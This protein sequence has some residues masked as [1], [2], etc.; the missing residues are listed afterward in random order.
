MAASPATAASAATASSPAGVATTPAA[1]DGERADDY[2]DARCEQLFREIAL[3]QLRVSEL[4]G[5]LDRLPAADATA[6]VR[7]TLHRPAVPPPGAH[8]D[9][10]TEYERL[11]ASLEAVLRALQ[12]QA[13]ATATPEGGA[14]RP[15][16]PERASA[17]P[18]AGSAGS[19]GSA[20]TAGTAGGA[21]AEGLR[22]TGAPTD[23]ETAPS[24]VAALPVSPINVASMR[25]PGRLAEPAL[26]VG[27][28]TLRL[29][30][31]EWIVVTRR[32]VT[33]RYRLA[34]TLPAPSGTL[35]D[36]W[37]IVALRREGAAVTGA[38]SLTAPKARAG[39]L[40]SLWDVDAC[41]AGGLV[42]REDHSPDA[43]RPDCVTLRRV[44]S[45]D[46]ALER[47]AIGAGLR[48]ARQLGLEVDG[49]FWEARAARYAIQ[50]F[51][52]VS[53]LTPLATLAT[54]EIA[55]QWARSLREAVAPLAERTGG[56]ATLPAP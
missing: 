52:D 10:E 22:T 25:V 4:G 12:R 27:P 2:R 53:R 43:G 8:R 28:R 5:R 6:P 19:A 31:G 17:E 26:V 1:A 56:V 20:G 49:P 46:E 45:G 7:L 35:V 38:V 40:P 18:I 29:P 24:P 23:P 55:A 14:S 13:C 47:S 9:V 32:T 3:I 15:I 11:A 42:H 37:Q 54:P 34:P 44:A 48:V 33:L 39:S 21:R 50:G 36:A 16:A 51:G 41:P 30:P